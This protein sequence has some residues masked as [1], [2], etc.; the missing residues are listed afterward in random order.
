MPEASFMTWFKRNKDKNQ[1][2]IKR[3]CHSCF[4]SHKDATILPISFPY[5]IYKSIKRFSL[6]VEKCIFS[7]CENNVKIQQLLSCSFFF[8]LLKNT[9]NT[10]RLHTLFKK[11]HKYHFKFI[12]SRNIPKKLNY[13]VFKWI[14]HTKNTIY[15]LGSSKK[16]L[17]NLKQHRIHFHKGKK[18]DLMQ[19]LI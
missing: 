1:K 5:I 8:V 12:R 19:M 10:L 2:I 3:I 11:K 9:L 14:S 4:S 16:V 17:N 18:W 15:L 13:G 6:D 7:W